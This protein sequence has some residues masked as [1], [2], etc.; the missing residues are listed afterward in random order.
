MWMVLG[1]SSFATSG[2]FG[3]RSAGRHEADPSELLRALIEAVPRE[4]GR[5][6]FWVHDGEL[7]G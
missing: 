2:S 5:C 1:D 3:E 4:R 7:C 6:R